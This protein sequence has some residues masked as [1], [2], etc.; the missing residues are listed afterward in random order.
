MYFGFKSP[1]ISEPPV[2]ERIGKRGHNS[3]FLQPGSE[4]AR[5]TV[6]NYAIDRNKMST[7]TFEGIGRCPGR[8][9]SVMISIKG[10]AGG[11]VMAR[12]TPWETLIS[13]FAYMGTG[14]NP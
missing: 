8:N 1:L 11:A 13:A 2:P 14:D 3:C 10:L 9:E 7:T 12:A 6:Y 4:N 5:K